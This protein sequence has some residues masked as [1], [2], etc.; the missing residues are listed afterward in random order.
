M[1]KHEKYYVELKPSVLPISATGMSLD[2]SR[3]FAL[4]SRTVSCYWRGEKPVS[5]LKRYRNERFAVWAE[6]RA[7]ENPRGELDL[8]NCV[9]MMIFDRLNSLK[10]YHGKP[11]SGAGVEFNIK[12]GPITMMTLGLKAAGG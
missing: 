1:K 8:K 4:V 2:R 6:P 10:K 9:A 7:A 12:E 3:F 11:G 5:F